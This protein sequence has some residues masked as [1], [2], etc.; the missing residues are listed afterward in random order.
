MELNRKKIE[1]PREGQTHTHR[2]KRKRPTNCIVM[3]ATE[4]EKESAMDK[5]ENGTIDEMKNDTPTERWKC[6]IKNSI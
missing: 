3:I 5:I 6:T 2:E 4:K 1:V